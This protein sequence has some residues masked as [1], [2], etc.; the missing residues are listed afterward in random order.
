MSDSGLSRRTFLARTAAVAGA[1]ALPQWVMSCAPRARR[2]H[3]VLIM[4]DDLG[5]G[6]VGFAGA[7]AYTTPQIDRI[8]REGVTLTQAYSAAPVCSPTRVALMTGRYAQREP[9]GLHEPL[10]THPIGLEADPPTLPRLLKD[11]GYRSALVGKWHLGTDAAYHPLRHGFDE[12]FGFLGAAADYVSWEDTEHRRLLFQDGET[13]VAPRGYLTDA[14]TDRAVQIIRATD[15][16]PLF[17]SL[18]Y[19]A[20]HWPWQAPG[21]A[22]YPDSVAPTAGGSPETFEAMMRSLD[23]GVGRVLAALDRSGMARDTLV[24]FTSDNGGERF[25]HMGPFSHRKMTVGE[26]GIRV[27]AA[28]RW[29]ARLAAGA[30]SA[31]VA[32]TMDWTA[33]FLAAAEA[34]ATRPLDGIDLLPTLGGGAL[35]ERELCW[36]VTQRRQQKAVRRGDLKFVVNEEGE[37]LFDLAADPGETRDLLPAR[38]ADASAMRATLA[39]WEAEMLPPAPLEARHR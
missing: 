39:R 2:P 30:R 24:V 7:T 29:P 15:E 21:D 32:T 31:Q 13:T 19:N 6:D 9:C 16:R 4:C 22:V 18:Q 34:R 36:R 27:A 8:A 1:A 26:G 17:L 37:P 5:Y 3:I 25:S 10:T 20:P 33:T 35:T 12:F 28:V 14:L 23:G 11:A 38:S